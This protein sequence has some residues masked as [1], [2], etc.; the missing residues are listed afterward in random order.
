MSSYNRGYNEDLFKARK[1]RMESLDDRIKDAETFLNSLLPKEKKEEETKVENEEEEKKNETN[2][3]EE[4]TEKLTE[5]TKSSNTQKFISKMQKMIEELEKLKNKSADPS[6]IQ[7]EISNLPSYGLI[8]LSFSK[9]SVKKQYEKQKIES[10]EKDNYIRRSYK[11]KIRYG[12]NK[13]K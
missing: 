6:E 3:E 8:Q 13:K 7:T 1:T 2:K 9:V 12:K 11:K 10:N 5:N 4:K